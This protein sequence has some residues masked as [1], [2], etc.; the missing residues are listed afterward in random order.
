LEEGF[1]IQFCDSLCVLELFPLLLLFLKLDQRNVM[2]TSY[3]LAILCQLMRMIPLNF[4]IVEELFF[5]KSYII[6]IKY[7]KCLFALFLGN[8]PFTRT[9]DE[10]WILLRHFDPQIKSRAIR[11]LTYL[12]VNSTKTR[13]KFIRNNSLE[14]WKCMKDAHDSKVHGLKEVSDLIYIICS[15]FN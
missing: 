14:L 13:E 15:R 7:Q 1:V 12:S 6:L 3:T 5:G 2:F 9:E 8:C 11:L 10:L 4:S